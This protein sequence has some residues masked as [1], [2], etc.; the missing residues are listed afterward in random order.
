MFVDAP[1]HLE[2][3]TVHSHEAMEVLLK[4]AYCIKAAATVASATAFTA[5]T[6]TDMCSLNG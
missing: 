1:R 5:T 2:L 3:R 6:A 4:A